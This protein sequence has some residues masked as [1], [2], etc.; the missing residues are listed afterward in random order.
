MFD[1]WEVTRLDGLVGWATRSGTDGVAEFV[2]GN[3]TT[4][5]RGG[6][7]WRPKMQGAGRFDL[8]LWFQGLTHQQ[9]RDN[10]NLI[11][12]A[13]RRRH[14][15]VTVTR[16]LQ[17]GTSIWCNAELIGRAEPQ[18]LG[19]RGARVV[20]TFSIPD[21]VW[22][23]NA[24]YTLSTPAGA[25][26]PKTLELPFLANATEATDDL[27]YTITGPVTAPALWDSSESP[28]ANFVQYAGTLAAG[29]SLILN[30][31]TWGAS[32]SSGTLNRALLRCSGARWLSIAAPRPGVM[33]KVTMYAV[34]S[35]GAST[36]LTVAGAASY[37][38]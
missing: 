11:L 1:G 35:G 12:R 33:P 37:A 22:K 18:Y 29:Q 4:P 19:Q 36:K 2:G 24:T 14:K 30:A 10:W 21:G 25:T 20:L 38:C 34:G 16:Y 17:D 7:I 6:E 32:L 28:N 26:I 31:G 5:N 27:V 15:L 3:V 23:S 9:V 8:D 13:T